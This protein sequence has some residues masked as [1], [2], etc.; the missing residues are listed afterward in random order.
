M[1]GLH[2]EDC[3]ELGLSFSFE[4]CNLSHS[5]FYNTVIKRTSFK[6]AKLHEVDFSACDLTSSF[7]DKCDLSGAIFDN[8]NLE[9]ADF[10]T[11]F[12]FSIDPDKNRLKKT[13]FSSY[14]LSGLL[15]KYDIIIE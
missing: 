7:F 8:T 12:N 6:D 2:F 14:G 4:S 3:N 15:N 5:L 11:S 10:R 13:K 1:L 9:K